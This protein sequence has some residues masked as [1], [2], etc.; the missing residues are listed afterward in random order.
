MIFNQQWLDNSMEED[1]EMIPLLSVNEDD[2]L[3]D[4]EDYGD[5][6]PLLPI[7]NNVLFPGVVIPISVGR[8]KSLKAVKDAY[9]KNKI[10]GI[11]KYSNL[12]SQP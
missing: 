8:N 1:V 10:I 2:D 7:R 9:K 6:V 11:L 12:T 4:P 3:N 5:K